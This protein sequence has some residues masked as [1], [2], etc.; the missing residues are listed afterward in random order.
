MKFTVKS[1]MK[2]K[3]ERTIEI[4]MA[5]YIGLLDERLKYANDMWGG[6]ESI[7]LAPKLLDLIENVG[8]L[9][10]D[11]DPDVIAD[12]FVVNGEFISKEEFKQGGEAEYY[13]K[14]YK[15]YEKEC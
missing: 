5:C 11:N 6:E 1:N 3:A 4:S 2:K 8:G 9:S 14:Q 7:A 15:K 13:F 10:G 12:N